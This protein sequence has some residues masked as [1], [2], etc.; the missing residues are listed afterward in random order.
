MLPKV[1]GAWTVPLVKT[2]ATT[3]AM[4][5]VAIA[6]QTLNAQSLKETLDYIETKIRDCESTTT[7]D[8]KTSGQVQIDFKN[9]VTG[10]AEVRV[11]RQEYGNP[12][13]RV[14]YETK[15]GI[16]YRF[17]PKFIMECKAIKQ[18]LQG[19]NEEYLVICY[20]TENQECISK[21][22]VYE[23]TYM[24][25]SDDE[26][27]G[28]TRHFDHIKSTGGYKGCTLRNNVEVCREKDMTDAQTLFR[29]GSGEVCDLDAAQRL[30]RA[31]MHLSEVAGNKKELF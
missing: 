19:L 5:V 22:R 7:F 6:P 14:P 2:I 18:Q 23:K 8:F 13:V 11:P 15:I 9:T 1:G 4:V 12:S 31:L 3:I 26:L 30:S 24:V 10:D 21:E 27:W 28:V 20:C 29:S 25:S 17:Y 16:R